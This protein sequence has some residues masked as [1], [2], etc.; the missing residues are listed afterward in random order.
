M[1]CKCKPEIDKLNWV[2]KDLKTQVECLMGRVHA[3]ERERMAQIKSE[4]PYEYQRKVDDALSL[5]K[6]NREE[7]RQ[8]RDRREGEE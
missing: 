4:Y 1:T 8:F 2:V 3:A 5:A 7:F 6:A